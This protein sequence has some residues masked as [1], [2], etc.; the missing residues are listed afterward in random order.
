[1]KDPNKG[2]LKKLDMVIGNSGFLDLFGSC[3]ARFL[4][5]VTSDD[6]PTLLVI[7]DVTKKKR[8]AF[9]F[10]NYLTEKKEFHKLVNDKWNEPIKGYAM[11]VLDKRLKNMKRHLRD[12]NKKNGNVHEKVKMLRTELKKV[13]VDAY[14]EA[15]LDEERVLKQTT[16]VNWLKDGDH[17]SAYFHNTLKGGKNRSKIVCVQDDIGNEFHDEEV[18]ERF[19][20]H[21]QSFLRTFEHTFPIDTLEDLFKNK[22][23]PEIAL[24]MIRE[25][26]KDEGKVA[27]FDIEDD[28][29]PGP[30]GFTS[31]FFKAS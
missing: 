9:R 21:F 22:V 31:K 6:C 17:N 28:K 26:S 11:F 2:L 12:L 5:Y 27:L 20:D 7:T 3:Y 15:A 10:M 1:M 13:Q 16:K 4:P 30:D 14:R 24:H 25:V 18:T 19:L 23:D 8:R 29:A